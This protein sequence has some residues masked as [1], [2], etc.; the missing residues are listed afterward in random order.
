MNQPTELPGPGLR[1]MALLAAALLLAP[2]R[3]QEVASDG[4]L[5]QRYLCSAPAQSPELLRAVLE[6]VH[7]P[8]EIETLIRSIPRPSAHGAGFHLVPHPDP[9]LGFAGSL[10]IPARHPSGP[11]GIAVVD[12]PRQ[13][14][15]YPGDELPLRARFHSLLELGWAV[16]WPRSQLFFYVKNKV[17]RELPGELA[18]L[19]LFQPIDPDR[20]ILVTHLWRNDVPGGL[21]PQPF[22]GETTPFAGLIKTFAAFIRPGVITHQEK[23]QGRRIGVILHDDPPI[24]AVL[25]LNRLRSW[26]RPF[27]I[28]LRVARRNELLATPWKGLDRRSL[29]PLLKGLQRCP[30]PKKVQAALGGDAPARFEWLE[31]PNA[32]E[33]I[34]L[35]AQRQGNRIILSLPGQREG[36]RPRLNLCLPWPLRRP[37][38]ISNGL[39]IPVT[40]HP[41]RERL[42][43]LRHRFQ[44]GRS[45]RCVLL[46]R[47]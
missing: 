16:F 22:S 15:D 40:R 24:E 2:L 26:E 27:D 11:L 46:L 45:A 12:Q 25:A 19:R 14:P 36:A 4:P 13:G 35:A 38:V 32:S 43:A 3:A 1:G 29:A 44:T 20:I 47:P 41:L 18:A 6:T 10:I 34:A 17:A 28:E 23:W 30:P 21:H 31:D 8:K 39:R 9:R 7:T 37:E 33:G 5:I 42:I